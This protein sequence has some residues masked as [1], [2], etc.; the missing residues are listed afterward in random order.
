MVFSIVRI[1]C[2]ASDVAPPGVLDEGDSWPFNVAGS[3]HVREASS[4]DRVERNI[5][6]IGTTPLARYITASS[7]RRIVD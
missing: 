2:I 4:A 5:L 1:D 7:R 6:R 3:I